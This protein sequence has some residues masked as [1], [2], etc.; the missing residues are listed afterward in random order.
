MPS[1]DHAAFAEAGLSAGE[2]LE[3]SRPFVDAAGA[4]DTAS[5]R[6]AFA[7]D[8]ARARSLSL[9]LPAAQCAEGRPQRAANARQRRD[10]H[11]PDH[12]GGQRAGRSCRPAAT[13]T[14]AAQSRCAAKDRVEIGLPNAHDRRDD[15]G[16]D[17]SRAR[18]RDRR[19]AV[20][21]AC[22]ASS[23]ASPICRRPK[24]CFNSAGSPMSARN[25]RL[26]VPPAAGQGAVFAFEVSK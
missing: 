26:V 16:G 15:A 7:A 9:H 1:A 21:A 14:G 3:F 4:S 12:R 11:R 6:L 24:R 18:R 22:R 20:A 19:G 17:R 2:M 25:D 5:F 10:A 13:G 23:S 8:P